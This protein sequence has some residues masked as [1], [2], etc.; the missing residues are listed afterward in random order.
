[1]RSS[2]FRV[3][4]V[5]QQ[6]SLRLP[7]AILHD[8]NF[9]TGCSFATC[10]KSPRSCKPSDLQLAHLQGHTLTISTLAGQTFRG[11]GGLTCY[12]LGH[13]SI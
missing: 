10:V 9:F 13:R 11:K 2:F 7:A 8:G 1:M 6:H 3:Q 5:L 4:D 12:C